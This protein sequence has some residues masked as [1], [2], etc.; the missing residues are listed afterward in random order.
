MAAKGPKMRWEEKI[1]SEEKTFSFQLRK[2]SRDEDGR[3]GSNEVG[4]P[5][6]GLCSGQLLNAEVNKSVV[7]VVLLGFL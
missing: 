4:P 3:K 5:W 1:S 2:G 6:K 7:V